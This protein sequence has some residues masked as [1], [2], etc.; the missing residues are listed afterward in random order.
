MS[1][2]SL[3]PLL[4][5]LAIALLAV[6]WQFVRRPIQ[7]RFAF[8]N[9]GA[10]PTETVLLIVGSLLGTAIITG[11]F[12]VGDTLDSSIRV[13]AKTQLGPVD[14]I[15]T[16]PD[17]KQAQA[18]AQRIEALHDS[19]IDGVLSFRTRWQRRSLPRHRGI[20][21]RSRGPRPSNSTSPPL[22]HSATIPRRLGS[23]GPRRRPGMSCSERTWR[24]HLLPARATG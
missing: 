17:E 13:T 9:A 1:P 12:I 3:P 20:D 7:R 24:R 8:R 14:E 18:I 16:V 2:S 10:R 5:I 21:A 11:S 23:A 6:V 4:V 22:A 15:V 19:R